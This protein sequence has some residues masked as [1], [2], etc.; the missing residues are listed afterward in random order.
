MPPARFVHLA[1]VLA[2]PILQLANDDCQLHIVFLAGAGK[3][4][5]GAR[6]QETTNLPGGGCGR[7]C[8]VC[9]GAKGGQLWAGG[10]AFRK[11]DAAAAAAIICL[12]LWNECKVAG[13]GAELLAAVRGAKSF[14]AL[15]SWFLD[16]QRRLLYSSRVL[17]AVPFA[18][19]LL[20]WPCLLTSGCH[21]STLLV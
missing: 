10:L 1:A 18:H 3:C 9:G 20:V 14:L 15:R 13:L 4:V 16:Q 11:L 12:K 6:P 2:Q 7:R 21:R 8:Q 19:L 5:H 17:L